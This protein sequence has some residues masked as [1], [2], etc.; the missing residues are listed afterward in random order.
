MK[1]LVI[2]ALIAPNLASAKVLTANCEAADGSTVSLVSEIKNVN[3]PQEIQEFLVDGMEVN[4]RDVSSTPIYQNGVISLNIQFG[5][6][7]YSSVKM[8]LNK[9]QDSF[10]SGGEGTLK[11]YVGGFAGSIPQ[12]MTCTCS[13]E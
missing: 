6:P 8:T 3:Q 4:F 11:K 9:C 12:D 1:F 13:L 10:E 7:L 2:L 5:R